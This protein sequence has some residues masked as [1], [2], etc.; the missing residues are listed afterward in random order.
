MILK[1]K[2]MP[3]FSA[4]IKMEKIAEGKNSSTN[5]FFFI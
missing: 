2:E 4:I 3:V 5:N 1:S